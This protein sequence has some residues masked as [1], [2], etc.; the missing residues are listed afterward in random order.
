M[1]FIPSLK[2]LV[3]TKY[4]KFLVWISRL[5]SLFHLQGRCNHLSIFPYVTLLIYW[6]FIF[7]LYLYLFYTCILL[8]FKLLI[9]YPCECWSKDKCIAMCVVWSSVRLPVNKLLC[10]SH[11]IRSDQISCSVMSNSL[12]PHEWQHARLLCPSPTP[13]VH[14]D[15]RPS[16][17]WCHPA[18]SSSVVP[19][20]SCPQSSQHQS[21]FQW[22]NSSHEV[23]K[24]LEFQL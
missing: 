1:K 15:S 7:I 13:R 11:Q 20:S 21:L 2:V 17:Q 22:V 6:I 23:A 3:F 5:K 4:Q 8:F 18:I 14:W 10:L 24:V 12:W 9:R 19:F 16:S